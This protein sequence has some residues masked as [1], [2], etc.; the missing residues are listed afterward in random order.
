MQHAYANGLVN[1]LKGENVSSAKFTNEQIREI[2]ESKEKITHLELAL[3]HNVS[4]ST[5][6]DIINNKTYID[7]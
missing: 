7:V 4:R 1:T 2:R 5:I 3:K 6:T